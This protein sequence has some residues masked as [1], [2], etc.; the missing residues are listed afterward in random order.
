MSDS[1]TI[2][3]TRSVVRQPL[4]PVA[5]PRPAGFSLVEILVVVA[6]VAILAAL[7][8]TAVQHGVALAN[9]ASCAGNLRQIG[10]ALRMYANDHEGNLPRTTHS[11]QMEQTWIFLIAEYLRNVDEVRI[12]PAD[13]KGRERLEANGTSYVLN[14]LVFDPRQANPWDPPPPAYNHLNRIPHPAHTL[15]AFP[16]SQTRGLTAQND[17]THAGQWTN[18]NR[19]LQDISPDLHRAG[20]TASD[21]TRGSGNYLYADGRVETI[22]AREFKARIDRGENPAQVPLEMP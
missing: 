16:A 10:M 17:H 14:D 11:S 18:W 21:R 19:V 3:P 20:G 13:P 8:V 15:F 12:S 2:P 4:F 9:R 22:P 5:R 6:I 7:G 1:S